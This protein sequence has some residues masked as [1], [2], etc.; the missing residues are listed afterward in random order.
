MN[1]IELGKVGTKDMGERRMKER[2]KM[3]RRTNGENTAIKM[4]LN[5]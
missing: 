3:E 1:T 4:T 2:N 5:V